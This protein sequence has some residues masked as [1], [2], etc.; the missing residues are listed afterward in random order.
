MLPAML[1]A[2][3]LLLLEQPT[4]ASSHAT[5]G[6]SSIPFTFTRPRF[7]SVDARRGCAR[8]ERTLGMAA[9]PRRPENADGELFVDASC[10]NCDTCRWMAPETYDLQNGA[11]A[12]FAQ[13]ATSESMFRALQ[14]AAACPT[15]SI[16]TET[17]QPLMRE[18]L[19]SFPHPIP[20][21]SGGGVTVHHAGFHSRE[22]FGAASYF[23]TGGD[24]GNVLVDSP[25][26]FRPL[27]RR[28]QEL[29]GV[30]N[31]FLTHRDDVA[32]HAQW[33][34]AFPKMER[35]I[36]EKDAISPDLREVEHVL[37][38][39]GP[40][41]FPGGGLIFWQPGHTEGCIV[42]QLAGVLFTGDHLAGARPRGFVHVVACA[43][44]QIRAAMH[45]LVRESE[46]HHDELYSLLGCAP[47]WPTTAP[48]T[49]IF[50]L[51][52]YVTLP[53]FSRRTHTILSSGRLRIFS[54]KLFSTVYEFQ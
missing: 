30:K 13:P 4:Q 16:R 44:P 52:K 49:K 33:K 22:S 3:L 27:A 38:G 36:H 32:D 39:A 21:V 19:A 37:R 18:A 34:A 9:A 7:L 28:M 6:F 26:F 31:M 25:R 51:S 24:G 29:G 14:A 23:V 10:I 46:T 1:L 8:R 35:Y 40:W 5:A 2:V 41:P 43:A 54:R 17:P 11:S 50:Y 12:V 20:Q 45:D 48:E 15:G 47:I 53:F 42:L